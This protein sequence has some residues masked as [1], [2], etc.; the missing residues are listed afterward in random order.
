MT[1][2]KDARM[3]ILP[4]LSLLL[5][6]TAS[7][8]DTKQLVDSTAFVIEEGF[9]DP[10]RG[11]EIARALRAKNL[12]SKLHGKALAE[13]L[14]SE[15]QAI[16]DDGHLN[17]RFDEATASTPLASREE[18]RERLSR[19]G[20]GRRPDR[21]A[22]PQV[23]SRMLDGKIGVLELLTF[24]PSPEARDEIASAM[25]AIEGAESVIVDL[26]ENRGG[27][28]HLV[29]FLASYFFP[30][31]DRVLLT[32][33]FRGMDRPMISHV[34]DTPTRKFENVPLT[35]LISEKTFSAG[36]A[37]AYIL[38]QF[39]RAKVVGTKTRG[40]G[41][42]NTFVDLGAG[43]T[44]S[45]SIGAAEHPKTGKGWQ[46]TGVIPDVAV[47]AEDALETAKRLTPV[48]VTSP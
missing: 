46:T 7:A 16:E 11:R 41:R 8:I 20:G 19:R 31:D 26:R 6:L 32:S 28:Q 22:G 5:T 12:D 39:G 33:R 45:V 4:L 24:Q 43:Y 21:P 44:V 30:A 3:R 42:P 34:V 29:D 37:F 10:E 35:I 17:V 14:T 1:I 36:E 47:K 40:G 38:Q 18:L 2:A 25:K 13:L 23:T 48:P 9:V 15:I 27:A